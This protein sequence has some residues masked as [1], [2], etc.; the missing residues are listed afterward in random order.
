VT[1][2]VSSD[3]LCFFGDWC[4]SPSLP[5][6]PLF[7]QWESTKEEGGGTFSREKGQEGSR[8]LALDRT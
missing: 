1:S 7:P 4:Y 8:C 2:S 3:A 5:G 6:L